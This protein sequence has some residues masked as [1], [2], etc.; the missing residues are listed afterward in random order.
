MIPVWTWRPTP[1]H[2]VSLE[3]NIVYPKHIMLRTV[4][5]QAPG[6]GL[7]GVL[8]ADTVQRTVPLVRRDVSLRRQS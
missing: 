3:W 7:T 1:H 5:S 4:A 6:N 2:P 8:A